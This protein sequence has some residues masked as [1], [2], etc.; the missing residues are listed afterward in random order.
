[1]LFVEGAHLL[2][3]RLAMPVGTV[4]LQVA[5]RLFLAHVLL[6]EHFLTFRVVTQPCFAVH[7]AT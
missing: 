4:H 2:L 1:M 7:I 3:P 5:L 6:G